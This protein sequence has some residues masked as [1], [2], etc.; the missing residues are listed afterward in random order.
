MLQLDYALLCDYVRA[1]TG[2]AHVI[3]AGIDTVYRPEV[4]SVANLG[5]LA[6]VT[7]TDDDI[8]HDHQLEIRLV[9]HQGQQVAR[10]TGAPP[11]EPVQ[12]LPE[13][14]AYGGIVAINFGVP[15]PTYGPYALT[16]TLDGTPVKII[17]FRVVQPDADTGPTG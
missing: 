7:F 9:D 12:G 10:I 3:A 2:L 13:G 8:G 16:L 11:L 6:R 17:N 5:L 14:W 15:L 4:P 1:E